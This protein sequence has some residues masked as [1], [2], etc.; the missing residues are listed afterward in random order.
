MASLATSSLVYI[1]FM[2]PCKEI[3]DTPHVLVMAK[4][5]ALFVAIFM[6][7]NEESGDVWWAGKFMTA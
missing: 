1:T 7:V 4:S 6:W 2:V 3:V 5:M